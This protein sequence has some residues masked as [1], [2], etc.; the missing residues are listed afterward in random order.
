M[1]CVQIA[2][3]KNKRH[4][5]PD[6]AKRKKTSQELGRR[7]TPISSEVLAAKAKQKHE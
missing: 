2:K 3:M 7:C 6:R 1:P 5:Q 4:K